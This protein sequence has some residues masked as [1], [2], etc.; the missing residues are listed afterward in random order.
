M[1]KDVLIWGA[2]KIGRGFAAEL[3]GCNGYQ[4]HFCDKDQTLIA[5][6][7]EKGN[8]TIYKSNGTNTEQVIIQG[9]KAYSTDERDQLAELVANLDLVILSVFPA[10]F[11]DVA[12][13]MALLL[14]K[15]L[16]NGVQK[17]LDILIMANLLHAGALFKECLENAVQK[18]YLP[19]IQDTIGICESIVLRMAVEP[20]EQMLQEDELVVATNGYAELIIDAAPFKGIR[21][22]FPGL[23][24]T[25]KFEGWEKRKLYTYNML[26]ALFAYTGVHKGYHDVFECTQDRE[27][28]EFADGTLE[29]IS[30]SLQITYGF[31]QAEMDQ[32]N[33]ECKQ[34]MMNPLLKDKLLRVGA[35]PIRK[36]TAGDRLSGPA[37]LCKR[38][39][40]MPY[41]I[42]KC[43]AYAFAYSDND[44]PSSI[45]IQHSLKKNGIKECA[46][47][48]CGYQ[49]EPELVQ[50]I[51]D[52]FY[53]IVEDP[54]AALLDDSKTVDLYRHAWELGFEKEKNVKGC[55]QCTLLAASDAFNM[56]D[57]KVFESAT[58]FSGGMAL[59]GDG[60]CG[61]YS[62]GLM[63]IGLFAA[64]TLKDLET[65][66]KT[67]QYKAYGLS[68][69]L[70]D[71]FIECYGSIICSN[72]HEK[73][74]NQSY[75]LREKTVRD[76]FEADG[77][78]LDKC[79]SVI[80]MTLYMIARLLIEHS[81][82]L[83]NSENSENSNPVPNRK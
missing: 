22:E 2:G 55:A 8:Y 80:A 7:N 60:P 25:D 75:V 49:K 57:E 39:G 24:Y 27:I 62:G 12:Q 4:L 11:K 47:N 83:E 51:A 79:T 76:L 44:D 14:E 36:L 82:Q 42:T 48:F 9:Y 10:V 72:I 31:E 78:H 19:Y 30:R 59:C 18:Q 26:H 68:A 21:P 40:I 13:E 69:S 37:L 15:R 63:L 1:K 64:R 77:A 34:N 67:G 33:Q 71:K 81:D 74:F 28:M 16:Q 46:I 54:A 3:F 32:W 70:H 6:L 23:V 65:K 52:R 35:D 17:K 58:A 50:L 61:G 66:D 53:E 45:T 5:K 29:E 56:F 41:W 38:S 20:T 73:I 43:I